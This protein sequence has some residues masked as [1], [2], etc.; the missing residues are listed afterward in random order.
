MCRI[1]TVSVT[2]DDTKICNSNK[3]PA[4]VEFLTQ[5]GDLPLLVPKSVRLQIIPNPVTTVIG[6]I[7]R[8][9]KER[10]GLFH[11]AISFRSHSLL[12]IM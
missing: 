4:Y 1:Q 11:V 2:L 7:L 5:F 9:S 6:Q 12:C 10:K 3:K 8:V